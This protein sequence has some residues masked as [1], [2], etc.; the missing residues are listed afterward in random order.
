MFYLYEEIKMFMEFKQDDI[1][2]LEQG[3]LLNSVG[4]E[5]FEK[6]TY[7]NGLIKKPWGFEYR[8]YADNFYD[9]WR[10]HINPNSKT[11]MHCHPRKD[12][13][14]LCLGGNGATVF[15]DNK[16]I[17]LFEGKKVFIKK[18]FIILL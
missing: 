1:S 16:K 9:V 18:E 17:E 13:V 12:T 7:L 15:L 10:L 2:K 14:L 8:I 5:N 11:S 4:S 3:L 6:D